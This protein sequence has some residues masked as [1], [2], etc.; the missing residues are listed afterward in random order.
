MPVNL[1][2]RPRRRRGWR[3][4]WPVGAVVIL[5]GLVIWSR[6]WWPKQALAGW[7]DELTQHAPQL[8]SALPRVQP[9][10][11]SV[12]LAASTV[13]ESPDSA[14]FTAELYSDQPQE[15][16]WPNVG[17][18]AKVESYR[19]EY[20]DTL[21]SIAAKF[22]LDLDTLRWSNPDLEQNPDVLAAGAE[23]IILPVRG[24]YHIIQP[25]DQ[26]ETIA[27]SYGVA[28][29]DITNYPPNALYPP[30]DLTPGKGLIVPFGRK[31]TILPKPSPA[32]EFALAW[33]VVGPVTGG[34]EPD[35]PALDI[36]APYGSTVYAADAGAV[37]YAGWA[38]D[39]LGY[40]VVIDHGNGRETWY[41][42]LKGTLLEAGGYVVRGAPIAEVGS[43]G[44]S[45]AP[46]VHFEL[47][48]DGEPV[49]PLDYLPATPQ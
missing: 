6:D 33:P 32:I 9:L 45:S 13:V 1:S 34:F 46:H 8:T 48:L 5:A 44:H 15:I 18:R 19:V 30:Y 47:H 11:N 7:G 26:I 42:H 37:T 27:A 16:P 49:N 22:E 28:P 12:V 4:L 41:N 35:H 39:G 23:L 24:V 29:A 31:D 43:T 3:I 25:G 10:E 20:G 17:G 21:W 14:A 2:V 36:G 38:E 40:T